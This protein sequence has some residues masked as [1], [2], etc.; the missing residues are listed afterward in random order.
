MTRILI[1]GGSSG[2]GLALTRRALAR[3]W[4]VSWI[5]LDPAE[6]SAAQDA[7]KADYPDA[8]IDALCVDLTEADAIDRITQWVKKTAAP[9]ILVNNAG[10]GFFGASAQLDPAREQAMIALNIS[11]LHA[12]TRAFIPLM[13][14]KGGTIANIASNSAFQPVPFMAVYAA[15]KAFVRHYSLALDRE[16][17]EAGSNVRVMTVCPAAVKDTPFKGAAGMDGLRTF[18]SFTSTTADEVARDVMRGLDGR[19]RFVVSGAKM[20]AVYILTKLAPAGL[21]QAI[22]RREVERV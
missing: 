11:A 18:D 5:S 10:I 13:E 8:D 20:R 14:K 1:T 21:V 12:M 19:K 3:G 16:L 4:N 7:L 2:I 15:T 22:V 17:T 9:D 6:I